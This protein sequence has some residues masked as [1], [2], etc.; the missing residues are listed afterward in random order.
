MK[1]QW[2]LH[3]LNRSAELRAKYGPVEDEPDEGLLTDLDLPRLRKA[4]GSDYGRLVRAHREVLGR[5]RAAQEGP[6]VT[7]GAEVVWERSW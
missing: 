5:N 1:W 2:R 6:Q 7:P 4:L 3:V